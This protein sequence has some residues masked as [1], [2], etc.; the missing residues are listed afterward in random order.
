[1][2]KRS[3]DTTGNGVSRPPIR[4]YALVVLVVAVLLAIW[5]VV[6]RVLSR[7]ALAKD[8]AAAAVPSVQTLKPDRS[9]A[10]EDLTLPG[11]VQAF[12][13]APIYARTNGY[14]KAW[15]TDIGTR[16]KKG[17][18]LAELDTPEVDQALDQAVADLAVA[19]ANALLA[20]TT[21][22]R[23]KG[24][25]KTHSVS[26]QDADSKAGDAAA[27]LAAANS[28]RANVA[29]L[30]DLESFKRVLAPFDGV[31]TQRN[32]D[33]GALI[34]AGQ[35]AGGAL[36][37][38]ADTEKLRIYVLVPEPYAAATAVGV[39]AELRFAEHPGAS[40]P[41]K[42]VRTANALDPGLRTL[43]VELQV[44]NSGGALFPGAY[45][46][47]HLR[48]P[49]SAETL[50]LPANALIFRATGLQVAT[51]GPDSRVR[52]KKIVPGRDFGHTV[53]IL[54]GIDADDDVIVNPTDSLVDGAPVQVVASKSKPV[55]AAARSERQGP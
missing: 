23:W 48:L 42:V 20:Q 35:S 16:V 49:G 14:L 37:R 24:L 15:Y 25:L 26:Q 13:E 41:A 28:A 43:Q 18:I 12:V 50:R 22:E 19:N 9:P 27:K 7:A 54:S 53:E 34:N 32:T 33:I 4:R 44:D 2:T 1:M 52:I 38:M 40:F 39:D 29:R 21:D 10:F 46:E 30:R 6:D 8:T 36:F 3:P 51:V 5:G 45:A 31:I 11:S 17:Q 47:V 55:A